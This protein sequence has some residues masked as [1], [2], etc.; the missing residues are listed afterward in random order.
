MTETIKT[1]TIL[2][3]D[4]VILPDSFQVESEPYSDGWRLVKDL[5]GYGLDRRIRETGWTFFY[6]AQIKASVFGFDTEKAVRK[7]VHRILSNLKWEK[8]N[9]L[10]ITQVA[11]KRFLGLPY[12]TVSAH[13]RHIQES[14]FLCRAK[15]LEEWDRAKLAVV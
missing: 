15:R 4:G 1:G 14:M 9:S 13:V 2:I 7:A 8:F 3:E 5:D 10:E 11:A 12:V 6:L